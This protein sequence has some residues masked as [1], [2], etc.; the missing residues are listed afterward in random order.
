MTIL[1]GN[2]SCILAV[3]ENEGTILG[4]SRRGRPDEIGI[5]GGKEDEGESA[6]ECAIREFFEETGVRLKD[7]PVLVMQ[8]VDSTG[9]FTSAY[10]VVSKR[11]NDAIMKVYGASVREVEPGIH[12]SYHPWKKFLNG[13]FGDFNANLLSKLMVI[14]AQ[15]IRL[16][17]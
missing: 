16:G 2:A 6:L 14:L 8:Q 10:L 9:Y 12:V 7:K 11:D 13:P 1:K 5:P 15:K 17:N 3:N 4:A